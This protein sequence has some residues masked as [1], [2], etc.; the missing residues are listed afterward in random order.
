M[1]LRN[2]A[3]FTTF[4]IGIAF[5]TTGVQLYG[6]DVHHE[7]QAQ[8]VTE[9]HSQEHTQ[10]AES[11]GHASASHE[12]EFNAPEYILEHVSDSHDWH[13]LTKKDG[14]HVAVPLP[15]I[16][17]SKHSGFH[18]FLSSKIAHGHSHEGFQMG[19][20]SVLV[21]NKKG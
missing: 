19:H 16:L 3:A 13:I 14:H 7:E 15:V 21:E 5:L 4:F 11:D 8:K 17:Y 1:S 18:L 9:S 10:H 12:E 20:G 6:Q 2:L